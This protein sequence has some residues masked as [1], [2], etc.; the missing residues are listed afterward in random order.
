MQKQEQRSL[1]R[2]DGYLAGSL[3]IR[4]ITNGAVRTS[5]PARVSLALR[6]D[7]DEDELFLAV[8]DDIVFDAGVT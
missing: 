6:L 2:R 7:L 3:L 5:P 8:V 1:S 4:S